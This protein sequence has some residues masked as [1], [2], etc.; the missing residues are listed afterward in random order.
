MLEIAVFYSGTDMCVEWKPALIV[1]QG[2]QLR[3]NGEFQ[4]EKL[5]Y[6]LFVHTDMKLEQQKHADNSSVSCLR[7]CVSEYC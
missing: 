4:T 7:F 6:F 3:L 2:S 5:Q 1:E